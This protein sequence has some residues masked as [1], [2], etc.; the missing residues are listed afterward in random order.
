VPALGDGAL[1]FVFPEVHQDLGRRLA[2]A[3]LSG[4]GNFKG[5][6]KMF[7]TPVATGQ[8][9]R[10]LSVPTDLG[11]LSAAALAY[12]TAISSWA[13]EPRDQDPRLALVL[14]PHS[15]PWQTDRPYYGAKAAFANLGVPSQMVT[16][17][18]L[19]TSASFS[20]RRPTSHSRRSPSLAACPGPSKRQPRTTI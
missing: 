12:R 1:L 10:S 9:L 2:Q 16:I 11:N 14:V 18:L 5:F 17:E 7:R 19:L 8:A 4:V 13:S 3:W 6:E 20:G 15:E